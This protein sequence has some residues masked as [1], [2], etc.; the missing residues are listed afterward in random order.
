MDSKFFIILFGTWFLFMVLAIINAAIRNNTFKPIF[1]NLLAHQISTLIF[2]VI[3]LVVTYL[4]LRFSSIELTNN[5][6]LLMGILWFIFTILF[7]FLAGHFVFGNS[8]DKLF[9]DYNILQGRIWSLV[10][11]TLLVS[12]Y[13]SN[14]L[15]LI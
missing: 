9:A 4:V 5:Q 8:W 14:K 15:L 7:E 1:G 11:I 2:I 3:I 6:A 10:L 13:V 12:P